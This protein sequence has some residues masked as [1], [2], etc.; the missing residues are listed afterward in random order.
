MGFS[1]F[2][3]QHF[4]ASAVD[5]LVQERLPAAVDNRLSDIGWRKLTGSA[6]RELPMMDH[7]RSI[8]VAYWLWKTNPLANF[9][10]EIVTASVMHKGLPYTCKN[11]AVKAVLDAFWLDPVNRFDIN[12]ES[13]VRE[14][15]IFGEQV[16][17]AFVA[18]QTGRVRLGYVDPAQID[19]VYADPQNVK[20][21]IG[22]KLK[23][24]DGGNNGRKLQIILDS[25]TE[26]FLSDEAQTLRDSFNDGQLFFFTVNALTNELRGTSDLFTIADQLDNYEQFMYDSSEKHAQYNS[27]FWDIE[28]DGA[29]ADDIAKQRENYTPPRT[30]G[31]FIHNEKVT[32][33]PVSPNMGAPASDKAA[34]MH[35]N[36]ITGSRGIPEHWYGGGGD[37]NRATASEMEGPAKKLIGSRAERCKSI[38]DVVFAF[39]VQQAR[40]ANYLK[41][42]DEEAISYEIH[43]PEVSDKDVDTL[44]TMLK[45]VSTSLTAAQSNGWISEQEAAKAFSFF[46]AFIGYE[47]DPE[48]DDAVPSGAEDYKDQKD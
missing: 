31:A 22:I 18:E 34:R 46:L 41:V 43:T 1:D 40:D 24:L 29:S 23:S 26:D 38:L 27:F 15:G 13:H 35:R 3:A 5:R 14:L 32:A 4:F 21:K 20:V 42:N 39:V 30:G 25:D 19:T 7:D 44:S 45:D 48:A 8:E 12:F 36:H 47:Y 9:I 11:E 6:T 16:W 17:P 28:V 2:M 33:N 37:V 10:I